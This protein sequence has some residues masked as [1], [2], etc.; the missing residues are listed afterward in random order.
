MSAVGD[1]AP[2]NNT[3][4]QSGVFHV[5]KYVK[6]AMSPSSR[7]RNCSL[8][9]NVLF[10][11]SR[12]QMS[13]KIYVAYTQQTHA[14]NFYLYFLETWARLELSRLFSISAAPS[15]SW[16]SWVQA[17]ELRLGNLSLLC[18]LSQ[19]ETEK[20]PSHQAYLGI[21]ALIWESAK[22]CQMLPN[23]GSVPSQK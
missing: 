4:G 2:Q 16:P 19:K 22:S 18:F 23:A 7:G 21:V 17:E 3:K 8:S 11:I 20:E 6:V 12:L 14:S 9:R 5:K 13:E 10:P 15:L 1:Q